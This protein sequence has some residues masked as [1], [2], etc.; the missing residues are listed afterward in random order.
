MR[1]CTHTTGSIVSASEVNT[2]GW[3]DG[4][5]AQPEAAL[6]VDFIVFLFFSNCI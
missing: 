4:G 2:S 1:S 5:G 3:D 6:T